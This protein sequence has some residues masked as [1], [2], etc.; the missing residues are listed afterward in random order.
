MKLVLDGAQQMLAQT[1]K[2]FMAK[3]EPLARLR[4]LRDSADD[5]GY[6]PQAWQEMADLGWMGIP[7]SEE[8]GGLGMGL[9]EV[10]LISEAL[11]RTLAPEPYLSAV[12]LAGGLVSDLGT[13]QQKATW[14][15][16][17]ITGG[18]RLAVGY[19]E[20]RSRYDRCFVETTASSSGDG[21]TLTGEKVQVAG[22]Y[23]AAGF[24]VTA[25]TSGNATEGRGVTLF[26]VPAERDG[27]EV[28][29]Q[30][31][32]DSRNAAVLR[33]DEVQLSREDVLGEIG[34]GSQPF[35]R[36]VDRACVALCGE[37]LG[38][39]SEVLDRTIAYLCEREQFGVLIGSFQALQH[40]AAKM[41]IE[42]ELSRSA[43]MA[44]ARSLDEG[45]PEARLLVSNAK[46]R[47][48]DAYILLTNEGLQ[49]HGGIGMTDEHDAGL[50]MKRARVCEM[51]F[52]DA[53][54]HRRRFAE[55]KGY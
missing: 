46:A 35:E 54:H 34:E 10:V 53:A 22:G 15:E 12:V 30:Q 44:A 6:S 48:S 17:T 47:C 25:R 4:Q 21:F 32:I 42:R 39:M 26:V 18:K 50:F 41:F 1:A 51:T 29:R 52:G 7:F 36:A 27:V 19:Q 14:L 8:D 23:G 33:L 3:S 11:G 2:D 49:M 5:L 13:A 40:R 43:V 28:V 16:P 24:V 9:A 20:A 31:R 37:M 38:G 55:L 45:S